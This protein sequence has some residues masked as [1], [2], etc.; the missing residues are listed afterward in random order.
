LTWTAPGG[1]V[2]Y[3]VASST[4]SDLR[5]N[6]TTTAACLASELAPTSYADGQS[7]PPAGDGYYYLIRA[8]SACG[9]GSY[10]FDSAASER[11][12]TLPCP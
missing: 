11:L 8:Q 9:S 4:L 5:I 12:P 7:D 10:G 6:A 2:S 3:D 1:A